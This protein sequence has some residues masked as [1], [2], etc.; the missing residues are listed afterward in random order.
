MK[1]LITTSGIGSR[2]GNLTKYTNKSLIRLGQK[3]IIS[4]I[5]DSYPSD[6]EFIITI[7][8]F[9][10][11]VKDFVS[12]IYPKRKFTFVEVD[13]FEGEGSSLVYS[14]SKARKHLNSNFIFHAG[15]TV[16]VD[17]LD[18][19]G[20]TDNWISGVIGSDSNNYASFNS[21]NDEIEKIEGKGM[22]GT[23]YLYPGLAHIKDYKLFWESVDEILKEIKY[24]TQVSDIDVI[25]K[26][27]KKSCN[28]KLRELKNWF[29][30]GNTT[31]L[32]QATNFFKSSFQNLDKQDESIYI[33]N[34]FAIKFFSDPKK[35]QNRV[36]RV[37]HLNNLTPKILGKKENFYKY[38]FVKG[39][40]L[41]NICT[42][43]DFESL[44][45]WANEK[46]WVRKNILQYADFREICKNFYLN[47]T[48]A[49]TKEF[50]K[51]TNIK[52]EKNLV[53]D[54]EIPQIFDL[55]NDLDWD[56]LSDGIQANYHGDFILDNIIKVTNSFKLIDW[57]ENFSGSIKVGDIY[58]DL[59]KLNHSLV[60]NHK[61]ISDN[62]FH[63]KLNK[64]KIHFDL[65]RLHSTVQLQEVFNNFVYTNNLDLKKIKIISSLIW[66]NMS[67]LHHFPFNLLLFYLGKYNL[68]NEI[69]NKISKY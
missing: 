36:E 49:R 54:V 15:D 40:P 19:L 47:K 25:N 48:I 17:N 32:V 13:K 38:E 44:L 28:F 37:K 34:T 31:G 1:V 53:N 41:S 65:H 56:Y 64:D 61:I 63:I 67:P 9:G 68:Y 2:L 3:P 12:L 5:I 43:N 29:D 14:I 16:I 26:M 69:K 59:A 27:L 45:K 30:V 39:T 20:T 60:I 57:R 52:D 42:I 18:S 62:Q 6:T 7:G 24:D 8:Y 11:L 50:F 4:H 51:L 46:L 58:Y 33:F 66:I 35:A 21:A 10:N 22:L 23:K 55:F